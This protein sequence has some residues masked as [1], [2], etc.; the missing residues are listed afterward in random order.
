MSIIVRKELLLALKQTKKLKIL[1]Q[2]G[3]VENFEKI[4]ETLFN[5]LSK[6]FKGYKAVDF[7]KE[8]LNLSTWVEFSDDYTEALN[9]FYSVVL[10]YINNVKPYLDYFN[11]ISQLNK[12][13]L[14]KPELKA[15]V[16]NKTTLSLTS[17]NR[18][19]FHMSNSIEVILTFFYPKEI[20]QL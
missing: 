7:I 19:S 6:D 12:K 15:K 18:V 20:K 11:S 1:K 3:R 13:V 9:E 10:S 5:G 8:V 16:R 14:N 17:S 2:V 4:L